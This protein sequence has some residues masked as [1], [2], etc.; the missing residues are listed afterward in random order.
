M[1][2]R[3]DDPDSAG[4]LRRRAE[5]SMTSRSEAADGDDASRLSH[6]LDVHRVELELQN[7]ELRLGRAELE[8]AL[9]RY[10]DLYD[11]APVGY[12]SLDRNGRITQCN[13]AAA[14]ML[15]LPRGE[16]VGRAF[17]LFLSVDST[18]DFDA[19]AEMAWSGERKGSCDVRRTPPGEAPVHIRLEGLAGGA[20]RELRLAAMD[21]TERARVEAELQQARRMET[22]GRLAG[23]IAHELNNLLVPVMGYADS[24]KL[25][26]EP[27]SQLFDSALE[28]LNASERARDLVKQLLAYAR[29]QALRIGPMDINV[30]VSSLEPLVRRT[31]R[32]NVTV[33][34]DLAAGL[35]LVQADPAQ[36]EQ[37]LMTLVIN[38]LRAMP[39]GGHLSISTTTGH[40]EPSGRPGQ[41]VCLQVADDGSGMNALARERAFDP[42]F[43]TRKTG[44]L[45]GLGLATVHGTVAQHGGWTELASAPGTGTTIRAFWPAC[46]KLPAP[47]APKAPAPVRGS[48][49]VLVV[50]DNPLVRRAVVRQLSSL[51]YSVLQA[52]SEDEALQVA[53]EHLDGLR[54]LLTDVVMPG[55][56]GRSLSARLS[57]RIPGLKVIFMSGYPAVPG[58]V[59]DELN[60]DAQFLAKPFT[61]HELAEAVGRAMG[62]PVQEPRPVSQ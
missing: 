5:A 59:V 15:G 19:F 7:E 6:E 30:L 16:A 4:A 12:L 33:T 35:P 27:G 11:F 58:E 1:T 57:R 50:E 37:V 53:E 25:H 36:V 22:V 62:G 20:Q 17:R 18:Q 14:A 13:L 45:D 21:V 46:A 29:V 26:A 3:S 54:A 32:E 61:V 34:V 31:T 9:S 42:F 8:E 40:A 60:P 48:G 2:K 51:G 24:I 41:F 56:S 23:G 38:A 10:T 28:I 39:D 43:S 47:A 49:V 44:G 55:G 52:G